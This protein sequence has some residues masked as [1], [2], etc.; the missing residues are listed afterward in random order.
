MQTKELQV[1]TVVQNTGQAT[2]LDVFVVKVTVN[3]FFW[4][5][6][7]SL[8]IKIMSTRIIRMVREI[9]FSSDHYTFFLLKLN[10]FY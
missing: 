6:Y 4:H 7:G 5:V 10:T 1:V 9:I 2:H 8:F 3:F